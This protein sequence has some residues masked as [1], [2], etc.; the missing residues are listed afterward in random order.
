MSTL[1]L[2]FSHSDD[3]GL[4]PYSSGDKLLAPGWSTRPLSGSHRREPVEE[5]KLLQMVSLSR[6][7]LWALGSIYKMTNIPFTP[8]IGSL[9][10]EQT[11]HLILGIPV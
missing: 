11:V 6:V 5:A 8:T 10:S 7:Q 3:D 1:F 2:P 9:S 4:C